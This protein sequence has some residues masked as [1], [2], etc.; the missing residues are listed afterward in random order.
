MMPGRMLKLSERWFRILQRLYPPDFRDE[1][2]DA[3]VETY[4]DRARDALKK[5]G[6]I[7]LIALWIRALVDTL[8]NGVA[9]RVR[10]AAS[11]RRA[12]NWG[13]DIELVRRRLVRSPAFAVTTIGT[14]TIGLGMFAVVYTAVQKI[15][16]DPMPYKDPGDLYYVWRDY[17]PIA[18]DKRGSLAGTDILELQKP[19]TV[20][21]DAAGLQPF[22]GGVF[23]FREG[24]E[25]ME[26]AV[27]WTS[28]N[29]FKLL[30]VAPAMGRSFAP[31]EIGP[32]FKLGEIGPG[33]GQVIILTHHLWKRIGADSGIVGTDVRLQG[34]PFT[35]IGVLPPDFTFV[36]NDAAAPPQRVDAYIPFGTDLAR[37]N[38]KFGGFGGL[39]RARHGASPGAVAAAVDAVGRVINARDFNNRGLKLYPV[40]LKADVISRIRPA[41]VVLAAAGLVLVFMLM[42]NL[43]SL[44]LARAAQREHEVAISRALGANTIV[45]V[46]STLLEGGLLGLAGGALG[47]LAANWGARA[48]VALA[49]LDLP[50]REAIAIDWRIGA[51]VIAIGILLGVLAAAVPAAWATRVSLSSLLAGSAVRGGG[52]QNRWRHGMVV[53]QV[54]ISFVLLS[55]GALVMRSFER[56]LRADPGFRSDGLFTV[57]VR[58]PPE[59]FP[60]TSDAIAFQDRILRALAAIPGVTRASAASA[61]PITA[62]SNQGTIAIAGAPGN[63]GDPERDKML[64]DIIAVRASYVE[65]MGMR[66]VAGRSFTDF[67]QNNLNEAMIDTAI[68]KRFFPEGNA[69]GAKLQWAERP[70]TIIGVI[71]QARLYDVHM[72]GR[73]QILVRAELGYR[74]L[75][76]VMR[77]TRE[78]YSLLPEVQAAVHR[79]D[80]R[81]AVGDAR[82][83][84]DIVRASLSPQAIGGGMISAFAVGALLLSAMGLFGVVSGSVT[85]RRHELAVRLALGADYS[86]VLRL[87]LK[88]G[89][90]LVISGLL[91]G[92]PGIYIAN[93]L[94]R[95]LLVGVSPSDPLTLLGA[96]FGLLLVTM[97]TCYLPARRALRIDPAQLLRHG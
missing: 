78:P 16:I 81:V 42:L 60:Q 96:A 91:I 49:P 97:A 76:Y 77:T 36:R 93:R 24:G 7:T 26:I 51:I 83:M 58:T 56:L 40:G 1:M 67:S 73:P 10:P 31:D 88:E 84:D 75:F 65:V 8:R 18:D 79:I 41:L 19:N 13:R 32:G 27:T 17:G 5:G 82:S 92:A 46:R 15:L 2:G 70:F 54:A 52:G 72:D 94:I 80:P 68:A 34:R 45:I 89:V 29:L 71:D 59:F 6:S 30:G 23:S 87:V 39:I 20:I 57:R 69:L 85:R 66:L 43:A 12:G 22:L 53:A 38:P 90:L 25:A 61:L 47:T 55:S 62:T 4:L 95:G 86:R 21:E 14:L 37:T 63:T 9:E 11:W 64:S 33:L 3:V 28:P 50:R 35:V 74:P 44:L 48:L